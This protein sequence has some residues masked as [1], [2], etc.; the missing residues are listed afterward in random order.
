MI[1]D[2]DS[3]YPAEIAL[4][5]QMKIEGKLQRIIAIITRGSVLK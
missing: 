1:S 4:P 3:I 2:G 5:P